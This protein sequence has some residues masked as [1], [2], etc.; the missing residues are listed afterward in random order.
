M[1]WLFRSIGKEEPRVGILAQSW[2]VISDIR[3][4]GAPQGL[5]NSDRSGITWQVAKTAKRLVMEAR[6][7][8]GLAPMTVIHIG[9]SY[10]RLTNRA[11]RCAIGSLQLR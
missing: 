11:P 5:D 1:P 2:R 9:G 10:E 8:P 6:G 7:L 4:A 3:H